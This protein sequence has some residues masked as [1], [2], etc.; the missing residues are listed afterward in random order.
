MSHEN[1]AE[2]LKKKDVRR[3]PKDSATLALAWYRPRRQAPAPLRS[4]SAALPTGP[5]SPNAGDKFRALE[6]ELSYIH[7]LVS[8]G[9]ALCTEKIGRSRARPLIDRPLIISRRAANTMNHWIV[10]RGVRMDWFTSARRTLLRSCFEKY[11]EGALLKHHCVSFVFYRM[12]M[13][14]GEASV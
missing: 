12:L 7:Q 2:N 10:N 4:A 1:T 8:Q 11:A 5:R 14:A 13:Y 3:R 9:R 6:G